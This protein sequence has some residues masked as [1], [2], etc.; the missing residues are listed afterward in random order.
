M[1]ILYFLLE[2]RNPGKIHVDYQHSLAFTCIHLAFLLVYIYFVSKPPGLMFE[3]RD[4]EITV[5][6]YTVETALQMFCQEDTEL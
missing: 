1:Y 5:Y 2:S 3:V 4:L 6:R